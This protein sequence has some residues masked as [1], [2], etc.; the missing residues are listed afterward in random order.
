MRTGRLQVNRQ[1]AAGAVQPSPGAGTRPCAA[2]KSSEASSGPLDLQAG[3]V[4]AGQQRGTSE[5]SI[6][7]ERSS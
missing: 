1:E 6:A 7:G 3:T 4:L 5:L 2:A